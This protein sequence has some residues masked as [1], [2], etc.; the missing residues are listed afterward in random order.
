MN[1]LELEAASED[2]ICAVY[3]TLNAIF[4]EDHALSNGGGTASV[5]CTTATL[6]EGDD[7]AAARAMAALSFVHD[8]N[9]KIGQLK[10]D[11]ATNPPPMG[12]GFGP[13]G[14]HP[15]DANQKPP[16]NKGKQKK[17]PFQSII[18]CDDT[19]IFLK[20][21]PIATKKERTKML[22]KNSADLPKVSLIV[23]FFYICTATI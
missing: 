20:K 7:L 8:A 5:G 15:Q 3:E 17:T 9:V 11:E 2:D 22:C 18:G 6:Q 16:A 14:A 19:S 12:S 23:A 21:A 4:A 10:I 13:G 1:K